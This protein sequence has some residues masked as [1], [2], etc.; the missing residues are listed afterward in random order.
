MN[1]SYLLLFGRSDNGIVK[2]LSNYHQPIIIIIINSG[3]KHR[4]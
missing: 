4:K 2:T 1:N 3:L